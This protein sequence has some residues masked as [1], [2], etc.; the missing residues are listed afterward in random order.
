MHSGWS[1]MDDLKEGKKLGVVRNNENIIMI[2]LKKNNQKLNR[3]PSKD[4][5]ST[6][7]I[8]YY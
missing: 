8:R 1:K 2:V 3:Y 5:V 7:R 6:L 4:N